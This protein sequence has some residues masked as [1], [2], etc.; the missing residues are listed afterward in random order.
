MAMWRWGALAVLTVGAIVSRISGAEDATLSWYPLQPGDTW[1]YAKESRDGDMAHPSIERWTT[2]ETIVR[3]VPA[4]EVAGSLITKLTRVLD[5]TVPPDFIPQNDSTRHEAAESHLL[6][7]GNC[8]YVLEGIDA[9]G[10][11]CDP[12]VVNGPCLRPLDENGRLRREYRDDLLRGRIPADFCFPMAVGTTWGKV[13]VTS[14]ANEWVWRVEGLNADPFGPPGGRTFHLWT[15][16]GS[17]T[18][19]DRWF[20]EGVG[21][22]QEV[23]EHHGTYGEQRRRLVR[24]T[25]HGKAQSYQLTPARTVPLIDSDCSGAGWRHYVRADGAAFRSMNECAGYSE[26]RR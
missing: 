15:H 2:E 21:V 1:V 20:V 19:M 18:K 26:G 12:N 22:V 25:I 17:G 8:V 10:S 23:S 4:P 7:H 6:T 11:A 16:L 5:H 3:A 14:P 13:A 9:Q 24:A